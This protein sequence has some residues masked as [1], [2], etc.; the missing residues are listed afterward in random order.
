MFSVG[1]RAQRGVV[2]HAVCRWRDTQKSSV[3]AGPN[4][5]QVGGWLDFKNSFLLLRRLA[6]SQ[7]KEGRAMRCQEE[8][9]RRNNYMSDS[10]VW[11]QRNRIPYEKES[12]TGGDYLLCGRCFPWVVG[13]QPWIDRGRFELCAEDPEVPQSAF[14]GR[15]P[16]PTPFLRAEGAEL[17]WRQTEETGELHERAGCCLCGD[18]AW[19]LGPA[20]MVCRDSGRLRSGHPL[21][22]P[23]MTLVWL[24]LLDVW[25]VGARVFLRKCTRTWIQARTHTGIH[26][27]QVPDM[28]FV[29]NSSTQA[30]PGTV[31]WEGLRFVAANATI[32]LWPASM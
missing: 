4:E 32:V 12:N 21:D 19:K 1:Q 13:R 9:N 8:E 17:L 10:M 3:R 14:G 29:W 18:R 6:G 11:V 26:V 28:K 16:R 27:L 31:N 7:E 2:R 23:K 30:P 22:V 20:L 15:K 24:R 5:V 25:S